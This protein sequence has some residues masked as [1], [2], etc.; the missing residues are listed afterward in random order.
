MM[1]P[2]AQPTKRAEVLSGLKTLAPAGASS[3]MAGLRV[4][5]KICWLK[6]S[7]AQAVVPTINTS[8]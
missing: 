5:L 4:K 7:K 6:Q 1:P 3:S 2:V 8:Q